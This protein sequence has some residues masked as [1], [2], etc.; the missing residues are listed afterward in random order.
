MLSRVQILDRVVDF[1]SNA[2]MS[3]PYKCDNW[4]NNAF[5]GI[6]NGID[7]LT[8]VPTS[9]GKTSVA[10][11]ACV[12]CVKMLNKRAILTTPIKSLSNEKFNEWTSSLGDHGIT[13]GILTGDNKINPD[14]NVL[15]VT[16][17]IL[18]NSLYKASKKNPNISLDDDFINSVGCVIMDEIHYMNDKERGR[19]WEETII[20]LPQE[21]QL[22]MLSG[23]VGNPVAFCEWISDCRNRPIGLIREMKRTVPLEHFVFVD[24]K[25]YMYMNQNG[26][27]LAKNF[28]QAK[29]IYMEK[30][31]E[32]EMKHIQNSE[33]TEMKNLVTYLRNNDLLQAIVFSFSRKE[34]EK[35]ANMIANFD[36]LDQAEKNQVEFL[37]EKHI[38]KT[39]PKYQNIAQ[40]QNVYELIQRGIAFHHSTMLQNLRELVEI[41]M[42]RKLIKILFATETLCI[43][44]NVP[45]KTCVF[46]NLTKYTKDGRRLIN[47]SEYRQMAG[48]AGRR[49]LDT[50]GT[51][52]VL[53]LRDIPYEED[54]KSVILGDNPDIKSNFRLDY[55][56][57]L[58]LSQTEN[59]SVID[60]FNKSLMNAEN[61][62]TI[63]ILREKA[64]TIQTKLTSLYDELRETTISDDD[65]TLLQKMCDYDKN[66][67][68]TLSKKQQADKKAL[69]TKINQDPTLKTVYQKIR[70]QTLLS[71]DLLQ[72][73]NSIHE[74][75]NFIKT[76]YG[77]YRNILTEIGY[78]TPS[79]GDFICKSDMTI[80]GVICSHVN[81]CNVLLLTEMISENYFENLSMPE[82]VSLLSIFTDPVQ[83]DNMSGL[84]EFDGT[85]NLHARITQIHAD[86]SAFQEIEDKHLTEMY[87]TEF[88]ICTDYIDIVYDWCSG[89]T[90]RD[91]VENYFNPYEIPVEAFCK[92]MI[93]I[94]NIITTIISIYQML[95]INIEIIPLLEDA[96][97]ALLRDIVSTTSLYL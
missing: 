39:N 42:K 70:E 24:K 5:H 25:C 64:C 89:A 47:T 34:C 11:Y 35:Y 53:P 60:F 37:F 83:K 91:I 72:T 18:R 27:Y 71:S 17:E 76:I 43:G 97:K 23:T 41:M 56:T 81:D 32:R 61:L 63:A 92:N 74:Y 94:S 31:K 10:L 4:Q 96:N 19:V 49:G 55:Q 48:R 78:I 36:F 69:I 14:A 20:M 73:N 67:T 13:V 95:K 21:C 9:G 80:K 50:Q 66:K 79:E 87:K 1:P 46:T 51:V 54:L 84:H 57:I 15:I 86:A 12:W 59:F 52:I 45:T 3:F 30:K 93:K 6:S 77:K 22:I 85:D 38:G 88:V 90:V 82:I 2:V 68:F 65:N 75:E 26:Q 29:I 44:V 62:R 33:E 7:V 8:S 16:A 28:N 58:K 40:V